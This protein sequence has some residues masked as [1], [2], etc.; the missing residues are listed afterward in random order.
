MRRVEVAHEI[1]AVAV[2]EGKL[3]DVMRKL[4]SK[5]LPIQAI[6]KGSDERRERLSREL[7]I[8]GLM[9]VVCDVLLS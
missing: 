5:H 8:A 4:R 3:L 1:C 2:V 9:C 6:V 7:R